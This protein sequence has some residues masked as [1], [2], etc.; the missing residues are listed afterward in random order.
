[1]GTTALVTGFEPFG[2]RAGT[3]VCTS[4]FFDLTQW[5]CTRG[6]H[7][8]LV[9]VPDLGAVP[10]ATCAQALGRALSIVVERPEDLH[11]VTGREH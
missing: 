2:E 3:C 4:V 6:R 1:M 9:H 8:G 11:V 10:A 7:A 5:A